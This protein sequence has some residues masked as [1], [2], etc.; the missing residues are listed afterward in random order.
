MYSTCL[1]TCTFIYS[2]EQLVR[3]SIEC[4]YFHFHLGTKHNIHKMQYVHVHVN[5]C[6]FIRH[7]STYTCTIHTTFILYM[8]ITYCNSPIF[9]SLKFRFLNF[10]YKK[11][12]LKFGYVKKIF[13]LQKFFFGY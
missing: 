8:Y 5:A 1:H 3:D 11:L 13:L 12:S 4:I 2:I 6:G 10:R 7:T 9:H